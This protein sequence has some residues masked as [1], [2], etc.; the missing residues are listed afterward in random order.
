MVKNSSFRLATAFL[1][2]LVIILPFLGLSSRFKTG[3]LVSFGLL[4]ILFSLA[5]VGG[6]DRRRGPESSSEGES[7]VPRQ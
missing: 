1:G 6:P 4:V 3:L 7:A 5:E 2:L